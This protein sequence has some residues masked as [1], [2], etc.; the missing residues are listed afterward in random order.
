ML[1]LLV[2]SCKDA[3]ITTPAGPSPRFLNVSGNWSAVLSGLDAAAA[4]GQLTVTFDHRHLDAERGLLLGTWRLTS[5]DQS[6]IK[7]GTV[8]GVVT[9]AVGLI[10]LVPVDRPECPN[11]LDAVVAGILTLEVTMAA[12][13]LGGTISA[14]GCGAKF[15]STIEL[16]R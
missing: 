6:S 4:N 2:G 9:G 1:L 14:Y 3:G 16:R 10:D 12:D 8:S 5:P 7:I 11:A 13:R 15:D